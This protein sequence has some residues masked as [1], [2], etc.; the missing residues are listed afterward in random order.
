VPVVLDVSAAL[1]WLVV[2][3]R[4]DLAVAMAE[5]VIE[6][7]AIVPSLWRLELRNALLAAERR[8]RLSNGQVNDLLADLRSLPIEIVPSSPRIDDEWEITLARKYG[9]SV[10]HAAYL[11]LAVRNAALLMTRD[12]ALG[13]SAEDLQLRWR[14]G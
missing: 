6:R 8:G 1:S 14:P 9:L 12:E 3:E 13:A 5:A 4:D 11:E 7:G 2:D 10:Y